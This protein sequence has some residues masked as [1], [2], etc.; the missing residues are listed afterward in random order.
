MSPFDKIQ[1]HNVDGIIILWLIR[2]MQSQ[3]K[4]KNGRIASGDTPIMNILSFALTSMHA[5]NVTGTHF[6][7]HIRL[8]VVTQAQYINSPQCNLLY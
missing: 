6:N 7:W 2:E 1:T 8:L 4:T 5:P 3:N